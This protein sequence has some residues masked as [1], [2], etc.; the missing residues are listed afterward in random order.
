MGGNKKVIEQSERAGCS[1]CHSGAFRVKFWLLQN[2]F[3]VTIIVCFPIYCVNIQAAS[4]KQ[5]SNVLIK[6]NC[7]SYLVKKSN[8]KSMFNSFNG[9]VGCNG[10]FYGCPINIYICVCV[11]VDTVFF[12]PR[13]A[14][15]TLKN[16]KISFLPPW[17]CESIQ[18]DMAQPIRG[19]GA[20][21]V[22]FLTKM[23]KMPL[24][25]LRFNRRLNEVQTLTKQCF[26]QFYIKPELLKD[27]PSFTSNTG[28]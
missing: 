22:P 27:R 2:V 17:V 13:F 15:R 4:L 14:C 10:R 3:V 11:C 6:K 8:R 12:R 20:P 16:P 24:V 9:R 28:F 21:E 25:S 19:I 26:S 23:T 7:Q 5:T 18:N 1:C